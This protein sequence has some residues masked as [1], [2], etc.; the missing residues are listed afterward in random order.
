MQSLGAFSGIAANSRVSFE[1]PK[2][3]TYNALF[4]RFG[5]AAGTG[6]TDANLLL[7][8]GD[9]ELAVNGVT[10]C[11]LPAYNLR[12]LYLHKTGLSYVGV[13]PIMFYNN[14]WDSYAQRQD[15]ALGTADVSSLTLYVNCL[16]A[17]TLTTIDVYADWDESRVQPLGAHACYGYQD[18]N[19]VAGAFDNN[20]INVF[21]HNAAIAAH[22]LI[23]PSTHG[24]VQ[25]AGTLT[26]GAFGAWTPDL[27]NLVIEADGITK[28]N[29]LRPEII[30]P[31]TI[32]SN[33][34]PVVPLGLSLRYDGANFNQS[35]WPMQNVT[36]LRLRMTTA[37]TG[38]AY[39]QITAGNGRIITE[40]IDGVGS[41]AKK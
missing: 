26:A 32:E 33:Y 14:K 4:I 18:F 37:N 34:L 28:I 41:A 30:I 25:P 20:T 8:V 21:S 17:A 23:F 35:V 3:G 11:K 24:T 5:V 1:L 27:T 7:E 12:D 16:T 19:Y 31:S 22:H 6:L 38:A 9:I 15:T 2:R 13:V 39:Q 36:K 40:Y 10:K 29:N